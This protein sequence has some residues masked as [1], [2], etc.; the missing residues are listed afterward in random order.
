MMTLSARRRQRPWETSRRSSRSP[1][2]K[3]VASSR[4]SCPKRDTPGGRC[5]VWRG[6]KNA[7]QG[8][9]A[10]RRSRSLSQRI[11][12]RPLLSPV[13]VRQRRDFDGE[14]VA[15]GVSRARYRN[16]G[17]APSATTQV[18][19]AGCGGSLADGAGGTKQRC[20]VQ[21]VGKKHRVALLRRPWCTWKGPT[22]RDPRQLRLAPERPRGGRSLLGA[23]SRRRFGRARRCRPSPPKS[24]AS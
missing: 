20:P 13:P 17:R 14:I 2:D 7:G 21:V 18:I 5:L 19:R 3:V 9:Q 24:I 23:A 16:G 4:P 6:R 8:G 10:G 22:C 12:A 11:A 1:P 15:G